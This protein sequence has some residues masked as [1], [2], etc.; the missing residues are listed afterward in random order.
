MQIFIHFI[1][2]VLHAY[3]YILSI[4]IDIHA[5]DTSYREANRNCRR[6]DFIKDTIW[7]SEKL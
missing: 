1:L 3:T 7:I 5:D 6:I 2:I 4:T